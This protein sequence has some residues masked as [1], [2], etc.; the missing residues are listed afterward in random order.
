MTDRE[1]R[2]RLRMRTGGDDDGRLHVQCMRGRRRRGGLGDPGDGV[3]LRPRAPA[4]IPSAPRAGTW[5]SLP[6]Q[7][8][9]CCPP[10]PAAGT[11]G[12][13]G[14]GRGGAKP[15]SDGTDGG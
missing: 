5:R 3:R 7:G 1:G 12:A 14:G 6:P 8:A 10:R 4:P 2:P 13:R 11:A 15:T 9:R